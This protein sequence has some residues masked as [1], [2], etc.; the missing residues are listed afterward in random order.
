MTESE[1]FPKPKQSGPKPSVKIEGIDATVSKLLAKCIA[2]YDAM[3][4]GSFTTKEGVMW[5][6]SLSRLIA[7]IDKTTSNYAKITNALKDMGC[8]ENRRRGGGQS[9][10]LWM[11]VTPPTYELS[12]Y[13]VK[14][15]AN[16]KLQRKVDGAIDSL[17]IRVS[18][19]EAKVDLLVRHI[20]T[21]ESRIDARSNS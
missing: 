4:E 20:R 12:Q 8:I 13:I 17:N 16:S 1:I 5:E 14:D 19:L 11:L 2:L 3:L 21:L 7:T 18:D 9:T 15:T 10:S 6:G